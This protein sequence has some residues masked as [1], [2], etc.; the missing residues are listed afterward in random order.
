MSDPGPPVKGIIKD[1]DLRDASGSS[2]GTATGLTFAVKDMFDLA[3]HTA[4]FGCPDWL[5][6]HRPAAA[7]AP[8]VQT[9]LEAGAHLTATT[10]CDELAFSLDGINVHYGTPLN[11]TDPARIPGGSS[12]GPAS[13]VAQGL[14]DF[15]LG[16]D[17]AGSTRV[18]ASYL[19]I[20]GLRPSA[21]AIASTGILP[22]G[23]TFDT[24]GL[25]TATLPVMHTL[26]DIFFPPEQQ[27]D[28]KEPE[29]PHR[30]IIMSDCFA[31]LQND[32]QP[33]VM[34]AAKQLSG[35][36]KLV[37]ERIVAPAGLADLVRHFGRIR[38]FEAWQCHGR[39][40]EEVKPQLAD[41]TEQ[42]LLACRGAG[43]EEAE[44][45][46]QIRRQLQAQYDELLAE[47]ILC[48]PTTAAAAPLKGSTAA[49]L[50]ANR[51]L[52]LQLNA[53]ASFLG[54]PQLTVPLTAIAGINAPPLC[55]GLSL[56]GRV[57]SERQLLTLASHLTEML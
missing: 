15:A 1:L 4:S 24:V 12:S 21:G 43:A 11:P 53:T 57:G 32:M 40:Y 54:L 51:N 36:F 34:A 16:T 55:S 46:R 14:V 28:N 7:H 35:Q 45:S 6:S 18:P 31:L 10:I 27:R 22:L 33:A 48:L 26:L 50:E 19:G 47:T 38:S 49:A 25:L 8:C 17:T 20:W 29:K 42:R 56:I 41:F 37:E 44:Q 13:V 3:G 2:A 39:W 30:L 23:P 52:N 5:K 9:L